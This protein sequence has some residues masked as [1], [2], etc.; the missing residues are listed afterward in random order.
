M[1]ERKHMTQDEFKLEIVRPDSAIKDAFNQLTSDG[2]LQ[3]TGVT[4]TLQ[5]KR[6]VESI[7]RTL[8]EQM[9]E[10]EALQRK[11]A[12]GYPRL[13]RPCRHVSFSATCEIC[14]VLTEPASRG[15]AYL[16]ASPHKTPIVR[17]LQKIKE[18]WAKWE[19]LWRA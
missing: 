19:P 3:R 15:L 13:C 2:W 12:A 10:A 16:Y 4:Y 7:L 17:E 11:I 14:H 6:Y 18:T 1:I 5:P 8:N 9:K